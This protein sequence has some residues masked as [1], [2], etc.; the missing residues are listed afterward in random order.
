M[1][2]SSGHTSFL[3]LNVYSLSL[4]WIQE[5]IFD[6]LLPASNNLGLAN[7]SQQ[8]FSKTYNRFQANPLIQSLFLA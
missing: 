4:S 6:Y 1:M 8:Y 3:D 2:D 5:I 7:R